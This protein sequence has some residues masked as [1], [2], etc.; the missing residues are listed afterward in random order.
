[1]SDSWSFSKENFALKRKKKEFVFPPEA[2][3]LYNNNKLSLPQKALPL[4]FG[5][6]SAKL[7]GALSHRSLR[8]PSLHL[9]Q[10]NFA[11]LRRDM[12]VSTTFS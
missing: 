3:L 8:Q 2:F 7:F 10:Q 1:M 5:D 12:F 9:R 4:P 11:G 6:L